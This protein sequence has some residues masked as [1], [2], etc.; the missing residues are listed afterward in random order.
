MQARLAG[1][2]LLLVIAGST[3]FEKKY[4]Q[5]THWAEF[6]DIAL[7]IHEWKQQFGQ[8]VYILAAAN[9]PGY[10]GYYLNRFTP[11]FKLTN[12]L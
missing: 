7:H 8:D 1:F 11:R 12:T 3:I 10:L 5:R 4:Y 6:K 9:S 2:I